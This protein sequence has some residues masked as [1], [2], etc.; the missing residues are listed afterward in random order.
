[1]ILTEKMQMTNIIGNFGANGREVVA[2][3]PEELHLEIWE[4]TD[5]HHT[6]KK[7]IFVTKNMHVLGHKYKYICD[8]YIFNMY[9]LHIYIFVTNICIF[10]TNIYIFVT[11]IY[12]YICYKYILNCICYK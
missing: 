1:M 10:V 7:N 2:H 5:F 3:H 4:V 8:K 9:L 11:N 6:E 12:I